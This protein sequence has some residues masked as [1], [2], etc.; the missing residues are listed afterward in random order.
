MAA[1]GG[2]GGA[3]GS[4]RA[5]R[6]HVEMSAKDAGLSKMLGSLEKRINAFG[7]ATAA[8]GAALFGLGGL[9]VAA[10]SKT[11]STFLDKASGLQKLANKLGISTEKLSSF[12]YAAETTSVGIED[13]AG[14]FTKLGER[15][16][17]AQSGSEEAAEA[18]RTL[19][20]NVD[21]LSKMD[22]VD[23]MLAVA[24]AMQTIGDENERLRTLSAVGGDRFQWLSD[25]MRKGPSGI[26]SL[27]DEAKQVGSVLKDDVAGNASRASDAIS[28]G[29]TAISNAFLAIG[30]A[31]LPLV[32][33]IEKVSAV[34]VMAAGQF[35]DFVDQNQN[36]VIGIAAG[37]AAMMALGGTLL[38]VGVSIGVTTFAVGGL[39]AGIALLAK[40]IALLF[41]PLGIAA[42]ILA[43]LTAVAVSVAADAGA[44]ESWAGNLSAIFRVLSADFLAFR[45]GL[46]AALQM[47]DFR[48]A[49]EV[50]LASL[51]VAWK[52]FVL[53]LTIAWGEFKGIFVDEWDTLTTNIMV[54]WERVGS[55][56]NK[57][58]DSLAERFRSFRNQITP[59]IGGLAGALSSRFTGG[60]GAEISA[61]IRATPASDSAIK[62][63]I[64][65][66]EKRQAARTAAR[67]ADTRAALA[68]FQAAQAGL[69]AIGEQKVAAK[70][71]QDAM[72]L[73]VAGAQLMMGVQFAG[74]NSGFAA[75]A[76]R[77]VGTRGGFNA[78]RAAQ[79]FGGGGQ[80]VFDKIEANTKNMVDKLDDVNR[81]LDG[82]RDEYA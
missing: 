31:I 24:D 58:F 9:G 44:F 15:I 50:A 37:A 17:D 73:A 48:G 46:S 82:L 57:V 62:Q 72:R 18:F 76:V 19:G 43:T 42:A 75:E 45:S 34:I 68:D 67:Q 81:G 55:G 10:I 36:L 32:G 14:Y 39:V 33:H 66:Q 53:G 12:A 70:Q 63:L 1:G 80:K 23:Q 51:N 64:A 74:F 7:K 21:Q 41:T 25:L 35:R 5:G 16:S 8:S 6:A 29:K 30:A 26:R 59:S 27:M 22:P 4:I 71:L 38:T 2:T 77:S 79:Q 28:R 20:L 56:I 69:K 65:D 52:G 11:F 47:G 61:G 40:G 78:D 54:M 3:S 49:F 13:L 60:A